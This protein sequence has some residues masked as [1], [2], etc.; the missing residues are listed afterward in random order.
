M[1]SPCGAILFAPRRATVTCLR[2][3][4]E[5]CVSASRSW[6]KETKSKSF[7]LMNIRDT[8]SIALCFGEED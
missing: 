1:S 5:L 8:A 2:S 6:V 4:A 7:F 3:G